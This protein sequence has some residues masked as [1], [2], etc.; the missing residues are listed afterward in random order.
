M[1]PMKMNVRSNLNKGARKEIN[2]IEKMEMKN[3]IRVPKGSVSP[4]YH[5]HSHNHR[6]TE[7]LNLKFCVILLK[8]I[9]LNKSFPLSFFHYLYL[10]FHPSTSKKQDFSIFV[11]FC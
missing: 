7:K 6:K 5:H 2:R 1:L 11:C 3:N 4:S 10:I 8:K 9:K